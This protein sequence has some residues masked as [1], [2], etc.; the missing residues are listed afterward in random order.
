MPNIRVKQ[1][2][3]RLDTEINA[4]GKHI[5]NHSGIDPKDAMLI[6]KLATDIAE[7]AAQIAE[8]AKQVQGQRNP[9]TLKKVR[10]ALGFT[11]P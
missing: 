1:A 7:T 2:L 6:D 9:R 8:L 10:R 3:E 5:L 11:T 4:V